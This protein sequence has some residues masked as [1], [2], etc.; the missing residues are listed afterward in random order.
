MQRLMRILALVLALAI[1][2]QGDAHAWWWAKPKPV[3]VPVTVTVNCRVLQTDVPPFAEHGRV[4][5]PIRGLSEALGAVVSFVD[6]AADFQP[7]GTGGCHPELRT[8]AGALVACEPGLAH[9][10]KDNGVLC[11]L[12]ADAPGGQGG[13]A[14]MAT[15][16]YHGEALRCGRGNGRLSAMSNVR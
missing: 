11:H 8:D 10:T 6:S 3:R 9:T 15:G 1:G 13:D 14:T 16:H 4:L 2:L 7:D 5:V 12:P